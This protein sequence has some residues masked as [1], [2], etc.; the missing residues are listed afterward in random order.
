MNNL[1]LFSKVWSWFGGGGVST[2][3]EGKQSTGPTSRF[4]D[5][6]IAVSDER[7]MQVSGWW[8]CCQI[9]TD[10]I[11]SLQLE[12]F[13]VEDGE[14]IPLEDTH[15]IATLF[16]GRP[17]M[18][19][20]LRDLRRAMTL[21][22]TIWNNAYAKIDWTDSGRVVA[23]TP[24]HPGSMTVVKDSTGLTYHYSTTKGIVVFAQKSILHLKGMSTVGL[25]GLNRADYARQ[26]LGLAVSSEKYAAKQFANGGIPGG[27]MT[28]DK[29]L[30]EEQR[31]KLKTIYEGISMTAENANK[32]WI[33]EGGLDYKEI[34]ASPDTLQMIQSR[35]FQ[36]S[37]IARFHGVPGVLIG[38]GT[39]GT[40]AWP[41]S[42]EQ[43]VLSFLTFTLQ[44]YMDEWEC[45]LVDS[46]VEP[47]DR[48][49]IVVDHNEDGFI[50]MDSKAK[51]SMETS[52]VQNGLKT[53]AESRKTFRLPK[54]AIQGVDDLTVQLNL[55]PLQELEKINQDKTED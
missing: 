31:D 38:A 15:P 21:Q 7:A 55:T 52:L 20:K 54:L 4:T 2:T 22:L 51:V 47:K 24:L 30:T 26:S 40:S 32:L 28:I 5:A 39:K 43:Q 6:G 29:F 1:T 49:K 42:F 8:A 18:F 37:D 14:R 16:N 53:R 44:S 48:G 23:I 11:S 25:V 9:I 13:R 19:M 45:S 3:G 46:L 50:R 17:N 12:W 33:L 27:V 10:S 41:S 36:L 34:V 35:E